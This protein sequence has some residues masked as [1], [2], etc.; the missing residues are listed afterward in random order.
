[1]GDSLGNPDGVKVGNVE[2]HPVG[3]RVGKPVGDSVGA[4]VGNT[5]GESSSS[6]LFCSLDDVGSSVSDDSGL[7]V[8][9]LV[10]SGSD[11]GGSVSCG[12]IVA[13]P[14]QKIW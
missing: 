3:Y 1:M 14:V 10:V 8:G 6:S 13:S 4:A 7:K 12:N 2:G 5:V 11:V 9:T